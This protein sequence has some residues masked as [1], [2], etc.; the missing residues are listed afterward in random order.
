[1]SRDAVRAR[2]A[3][4]FEGERQRRR[5]IV[6]ELNPD[7][8]FFVHRPQRGLLGAMRPSIEGRLIADASAGC[9]VLFHVAYP[10][11]WWIAAACLFVAMTAQLLRGD[12][13]QRLFFVS[14][15]SVLVVLAIVPLRLMGAAFASRLEKALAQ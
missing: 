15:L 12:P 13:N 4:M 1:M 9:D 7:D 10:P 3:A 2:L 11:L 6:A 5:R 8:S 14:C